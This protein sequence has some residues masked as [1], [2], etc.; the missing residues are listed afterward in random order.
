M[1]EDQ[2]QPQP[3]QDM[4]VQPVS[5]PETQVASPVQPAVIQTTTPVSSS[6]SPVVPV[7]TQPAVAA[8]PIASG[9]DKVWISKE[10]YARLTQAQ[11]AQH[12]AVFTSNPPPQKLFGAVQTVT[13]VT[14][15][16]GVLL[17]LIGGGTASFFLVPSL[18][19][20]VLMGV[21]TFRDYT[22]AKTDGYVAPHKGRNN[23]LLILS[24]VVL[25]SPVLMIVFF[26][27]LIS[28]SCAGGACRGS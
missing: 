28:L 1:P 3:M 6:P 22:K 17:G 12:R 24:L 7:S 11:N 20:L 27:L 10:E 4:P 21:F 13:A 5:F 23:T 15:A 14:A 19:I 26:V 8:A 9:D 2:Q 16:L 25:A 18:I